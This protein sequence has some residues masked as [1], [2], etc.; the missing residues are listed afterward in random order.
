MGSTTPA[1]NNDQFGHKPQSQEDELELNGPWNSSP[2]G[3][4][5]KLGLDRMILVWRV[6][7][8]I[9]LYRENFTV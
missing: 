7:V 3:C 2:K 5:F 8:D 6:S 9:P 4:K 1:Y